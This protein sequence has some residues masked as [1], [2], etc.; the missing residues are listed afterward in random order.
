MSR[1]RPCGPFSGATGSAVGRGFTL[2]ELAVIIALM[3]ILAAVAVPTLDRI[4]ESRA[5]MASSM[6]ARDLAFA[7]Q[8]AVATGRRTWLVV[9]ED[10]DGWDLLVEPAGSQDRS[11]AVPMA[12]EIT[13]RVRTRSLSALGDDDVTVANVDVDGE[14][15]I[16]FDWRGRPL[17]AAEA[18]CAADALFTMSS[19]AVVTVVKETGFV[20]DATP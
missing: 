18:D 15:E 16:G 5:G 19:G 20:R 17:N 10:G 6:L 14:R 11:A 8:Y 13:G 1:P 4:G 2:V 9:R 12:D 3:A 7:R